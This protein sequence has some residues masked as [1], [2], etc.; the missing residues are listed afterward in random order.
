MRRP[1]LLV[2][3]LLAVA[4]GALGIFVPLLPT[5]PFLLLAVWCFARSSERLHRW[6]RGQKHLGPILTHWELHRAVRPRV[7]WVATAMILLLF[8]HQ[9]AFGTFHPWIEL[10][11]GACLTGVLA[12]LWTRPSRPAAAP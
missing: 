10:A 8:S 1:L 5:T 7:K 12:F 11:A 3:G 9:L 2:A 4:L 6:L